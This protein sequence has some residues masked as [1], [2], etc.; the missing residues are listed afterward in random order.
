MIANGTGIAPFRSIAQYYS[1]QKNE[2]RI[3]M[4]LYY[5]IQNSEVD[6]YFKSDFE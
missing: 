5:G 3:P 1:T 6:Y 2:N 4:K